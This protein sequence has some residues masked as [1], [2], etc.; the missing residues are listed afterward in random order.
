[1]KVIPVDTYKEQDT[2]QLDFY[3]GKTMGFTLKTVP[4]EEALGQA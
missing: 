3:D 1:M 4:L 2:V